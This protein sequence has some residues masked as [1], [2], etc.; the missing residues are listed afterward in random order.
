MTQTRKNLVLRGEQLRDLDRLAAEWTQ[1]PAGQPRDL[2]Q[3]TRQGSIVSRAGGPPWA[4]DRDG[5]W[6]VTSGTLIRYAIA[7]L[8][9]KHQAPTPPKR[10]K[11]TKRR[12]R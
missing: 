1:R 10:K 2:A 8:L 7:R 11:A 6:P 12:K 3:V 4:L 9:A 5:N